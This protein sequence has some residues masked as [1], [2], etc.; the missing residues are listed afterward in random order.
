[1][2]KK[3]EEELFLAHSINYLLA[4]GGVAF[5]NLILKVK[6]EAAEKNLRY[7]WSMNFVFSGEPASLDQMSE[8][9]ATLLEM[10]ADT[11]KLPEDIAQESSLKRFVAE[12]SSALTP[13]EQRVIDLRFGLNGNAP[14]TLEEVGAEFNVTRER[15]RQIEA[16][17]LEKL[18]RKVRI[19][20]ISRDIF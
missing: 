7:D 11:G 12:L 18:K 17:A 15:I 9:G 6:E 19:D 16:K 4:Y 2:R 3:L 20:K 1:M 10:T 8:E 5:L 13:K 14:K